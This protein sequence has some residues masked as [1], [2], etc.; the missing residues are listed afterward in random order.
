MQDRIFEE[1]SNIIG[2]SDRS[3]TAIEFAEMKYLDAVIKEILRLYPS[4]PN[5]G[6]T[7]VEEF[8]LGK[9]LDLFIKKNQSL[10]TNAKV[11][12]ANSRYFENL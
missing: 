12:F 4:V 8:Y 5:I 11:T 10:Y 3:P 2:D 9:W 1:Y 7:V 6:R